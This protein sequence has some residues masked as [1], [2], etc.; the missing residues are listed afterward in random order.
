MWRCSCSGLSSSQLLWLVLGCSW[1]AIAAGQ[2]QQDPKTDP[3]EVA[4]LNTILGRWGTKASPEWNISGE[5]CSGAV[6]DKSYWNDGRKQLAIMCNCSYKSNTVCH[7][8]KL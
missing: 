7:V 1:W 6:T 5:P 3:V 8:T 4:A 2:A